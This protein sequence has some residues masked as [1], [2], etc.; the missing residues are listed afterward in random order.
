MKYTHTNIGG[1][2]EILASKD[3]QAIPIEVA[4]PASGTVVKAGTPLTAAGAVAAD[5]SGAAGIL[6]YD[7]DTAENPNGALVVQG[8]V[9]ALKCVAHSGVSLS[10]FS[11]PGIVLRDNIRAI[12]TDAELSA[13]EIGSLALTPEFDAGVTAYTAATTNT[14]DSVTATANDALATAVIKNG[15]TTVTSGNNATWSAGKNTVTVTVTAEDGVT[16]KTYTVEVTKS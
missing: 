12:G 14:Q 13:L 8:I 11:V 16:T 15:T 2:V 5:G 6:L 1:S 3:F 4:T 7:V 10:S 9:D